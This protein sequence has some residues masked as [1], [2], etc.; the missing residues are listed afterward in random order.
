M[1][2]ENANLIANEPENDP[3]DNN[4]PQQSEY[5]EERKFLFC[6]SFKCGVTFFG[7]FIALD[8]TFEIFN[9]AYIAT[10]P[11]FDSIFSI[12]YGFMMLPILGA[13]FIFVYYWIS[14]E[15]HKVRKQLTWGL[16]LSIIGS[17]LIVIWIILYIAAFYPN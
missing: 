16:V 13:F 7:L 17:F 14:A 12:I 8:L 15:S 2:D 3:N 11:Y 1:D 10:N 5:K 6:F 4:P 9:V